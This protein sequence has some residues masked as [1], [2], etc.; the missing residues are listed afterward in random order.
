LPIAKL[1]AATADP[2]PVAVAERAPEQES[3]NLPGWNPDRRLLVMRL[4]SRGKK[5]DQI[6]AALRIPQQEVEQFLEANH[7]APRHSAD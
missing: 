5:A 2:A 3:V 1:S 4:A 7:L 6:A